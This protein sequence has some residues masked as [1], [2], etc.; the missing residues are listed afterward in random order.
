MPGTISGSGKI[1]QIGGPW[2]ANS[3]AAENWWCVYVCMNV[4]WWPFLPPL[5][6][7]P[8]ASSREMTA[9]SS[10]QLRL[11]RLDARFGLDVDPVRKT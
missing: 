10:R 9:E 8:G 7:E 1:K 5:A 4:C 3:A 11:R 2:L 6:V